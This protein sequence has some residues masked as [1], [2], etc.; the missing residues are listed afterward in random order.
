MVRA[1]P[2]HQGRRI[3]LVGV[4]IFLGLA[5]A[6]RQTT[7]WGAGHDVQIDR[8]GLVVAA[9]RSLIEAAR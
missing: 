1:R 2:F 4:A 3:P 5:L 7:A 9:T 8:P 6:V